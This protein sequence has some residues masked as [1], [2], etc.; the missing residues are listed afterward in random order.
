VGG[1]WYSRISSKPFVTLLREGP[2]PVIEEAGAQYLGSI[3]SNN[4]LPR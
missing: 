2:A 1:Q 3:G 4:N